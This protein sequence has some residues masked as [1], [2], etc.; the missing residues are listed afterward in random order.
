MEDLERCV[1]QIVLSFVES[2]CFLRFVSD[3]LVI[4]RQIRRRRCSLAD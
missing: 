4:H 2:V 1:V 3:F